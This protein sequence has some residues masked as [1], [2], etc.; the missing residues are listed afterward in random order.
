MH[1]IRE[2]RRQPGRSG[3]TL[4]ELLVVIAII[5]ILIA[6]LLPA[7]QQARE[8]ARRT[9]C[10]NNLKQISLAFHNHHDVH[11]IFPT[12]G[13]HWSTPP[14]FNS[15]SP[16]TGAAQPAG[17]GYQILPYVEQEQLWLGGGGAT[18]DDKA[19]I[20]IQTPVPVH[21]CPSRRAPQAHAPRGNWYNPRQTFGHAMN[22]Y[23]GCGGTNGGNGSDGAVVRTNG[24]SGNFIQEANG[25][26]HITD[27]TSNTIIVGEKRLRDRYLTYQGDDNE[28]YS[29]GWDHDVIRWT[30][31]VPRPD[32]RSGFGDYR[33]GSI[34]PGGFHAAIADGS[35]RFINYS[36]D[37]TTFR[38]LGVKNDGQT[39]SAF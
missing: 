20:I 1:R 23:A 34:H 12:G 31:R 19:A 16:E 11:N 29:S 36:I 3:F 24:T 21:F 15:G 18:D 9:R 25:M 13:W 32:S 26:R 8:S 33:F 39:V 17:W 37:A 5:A 4:I 22:D 28:G 6:L 7:V 2:D 35:V 30:N 14:K 27:G 10:R 38:R